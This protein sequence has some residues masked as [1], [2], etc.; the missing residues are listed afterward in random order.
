M[1][2]KDKTVKAIN[3]EGTNYSKPI[4]IVPSLGFNVGKVD[5]NAANKKVSVKSG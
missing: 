2:G 1:Y 4:D 5:Y 3:F